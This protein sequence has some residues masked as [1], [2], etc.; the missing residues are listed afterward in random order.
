[1]FEPDP[2]ARHSISKRLSKKYQL[3][4]DQL[5]ASAIP[6][7]ASRTKAVRTSVVSLL[8]KEA[9]SANSAWEIPRISKRIFGLLEDSKAAKL[10]GINFDTELDILNQVLVKVLEKRILTGY[11]GNCRHGESL[12]NAYIDVFVTATLPDTHRAFEEKPSFLVNP[13]TGMPIELDVMLEDFRLAFEFQGHSDHYTIPEV[14]AKDAFKLAQCAAFSRVL[15]PVN[16]SQLSG[17]VLSSLILNSIISYLRIGDILSGIKVHNARDLQV[18]N[19]ALYRFS[20]AAQ[21]IYLAELLYGQAIAWLDTKS[22]SFISDMRIRS[23]HSSTMPA[24]KLHPMHP[25]MSV[26]DIYRRLPNIKRYRNY[27]SACK[28]K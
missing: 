10:N 22:A 28:R 14:M 27:S 15:I 17:S 1:M 20:K 7:F 23:P 16:I 24:P 3:A 12:L 13:N 6:R 5:G 4:I 11:N 2:R 9:G 25:E 8:R 18:S 19:E 21:R 26:Y